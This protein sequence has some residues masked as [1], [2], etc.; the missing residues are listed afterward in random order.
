MKKILCV[1]LAVLTC[2]AFSSCGSEAELY[3]KYKHLIDKLEDGNYQGAISEIYYL[4][5]KSEAANADGEE[6]EDPYITELKG[7]SIGEWIPSLRSVE[8]YGA[9]P[10][11]LNE[12][13]TFVMGEEKLSWIVLNE[14]TDSVDYDVHKDGE[15]IYRLSIRQDDETPRMRLSKYEEDHW[16]EIGTYY[17]SS[18]YDVVEITLDNWQEYFEHYEDVKQ[19]RNSFNEVS[20]LSVYFGYR[21]NDAY[22]VN[23]DLSN[24]AVEYSTVYRWYNGTADLDAGTYEKG[25]VSEHSDDAEASPRTGKLTESADY[26]Y[27]FSYGNTNIDGPEDNA[28]FYDDFEMVRIAGKIYLAKGE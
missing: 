18:D 11:R 26:G 16:Y 14:Y 10:F 19:N 17:L 27:G 9:I 28:P 20:S 22:R 24:V 8:D 2:L 4:A 12:D 21:L 5:E 6:T 3:N 1:L 23:C 15:K 7:L 13:H 25:V